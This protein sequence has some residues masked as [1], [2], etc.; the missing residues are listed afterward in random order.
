MAVATV[1]AAD[2]AIRPGLVLAGVAAVGAAGVAVRPGLVLAGIAAVG[3]ADVAV[4]AGLAAARL[5]DSLQQG[6][7][8]EVWSVMS[9]RSGDVG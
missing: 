1:G 4:R 2:I 5:A 9:G 6:F 3:A 8:E 7:L